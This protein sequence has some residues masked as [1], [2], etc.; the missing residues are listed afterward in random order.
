[1]ESKGLPLTSEASPLVPSK[2]PSRQLFMC[3]LAVLGPGVLS[4]L[5]DSD[6]PCIFVAGD[7][8][9]RYGY[10]AII[11]LQILLVIPLFVTQELTVRLGVYTQL[12]F[13][14]CIRKEFGPAAAWV[15]FCFVFIINVLTT[16]NELAGIAGACVVCGLDN[17][18]GATIAAV[19]LLVIVQAPYRIVERIG[20]ALGLAELAF[21]VA[22]AL[23]RPDVPATVV[24]FTKVVPTTMFTYVAAA[25][26]GAV[27][28][29][30]MVYFQQAAI[31]SKRMT[32][33]KEEAVE[34]MGSVVGA[35]TTQ[36]IMVATM[37]L[38]AATREATGVRVIEN[39]PDLSVVLQIA[40]GRTM[41]K[42]LLAA[43]LIGGSGCAALVVALTT[44]W[45]LCE[46]LGLDTKK[47]NPMDLPFWKAP[48]FYGTYLLVI[49]V[50]LGVQLSGVTMEDMSL[51]ALAA[52]AFLMPLILAFLWLLATGPIMPE[53]VRVTGVH[54]WAV[55]VVFVVLSVFAVVSSAVGAIGWTVDDGGE[56][57][58]SSFAH[59]H[60]YR[61]DHFISPANYNMS[62]GRSWVAVSRPQ[63]SSMLSGP[64]PSAPPLLYPTQ[65]YDTRHDDYY[66]TRAS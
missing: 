21:V 29:C 52:N 27:I 30:W 33:G 59:R 14:A 3:G 62:I 46:T 22:W 23:A 25:N 34:R 1:M 50:G 55:F 10:S 57:V 20:I 36:A 35:V 63:L 31:A 8:G 42:A 43:G 7:S 19:L 49:L 66:E 4:A 12:G 39:V 58:A 16:I 48:A 61:A 11:L 44:S 2:A 37:C 40:F 18:V 64:P 65:S 13:G 41:G 47:A 38:L 51:I 54:K 17:M 53:A 28:P 9:A 24:G 45:A 5:A 60:A 56:E 15:T 32:A 26:V 6:A